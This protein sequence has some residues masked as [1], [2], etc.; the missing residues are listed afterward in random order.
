MKTGCERHTKFK[1]SGPWCPICT[2]AES[3]A[4]LEH[5]MTLLGKYFLDAEGYELVAHIRAHLA[6]HGDIPSD[7]K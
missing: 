3:D 5:A 7:G 4:L 2:E 6:R 1:S